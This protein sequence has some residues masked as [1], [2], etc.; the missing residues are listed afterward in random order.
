MEL[1]VDPGSDGVTITVD[2]EIQGAI[3][4][5]YR[6]PQD[7]LAELIDELQGHTL[8]EFVGGGWPTCPRHHTHPLI[9]TAR[10]DD[11][12]WICPTDDDV[13]ARVG[14]LTEVG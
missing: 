10:G 5:P 4:P 8:H 11:T 12:V 13:I 9:A 3:W 14:T 6:K 1:S 2:G 7:H